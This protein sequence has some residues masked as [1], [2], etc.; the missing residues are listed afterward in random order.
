MLRKMVYLF[1]IF[2]TLFALSGCGTVTNSDD[3]ANNVLSN[4]TSMSTANIDEDSDSSASMTDASHSNDADPDYDTVFPQDEVNRID[5]T[6]SEE[7]W[8]AMLGGYD[9]T[10]W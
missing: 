4:E 9:R 3:Q 7:N 1:V 2:T 10:L 8:E 5:I 6:I